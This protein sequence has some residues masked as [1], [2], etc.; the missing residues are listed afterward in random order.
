MRW[1]YKSALPLRSRPASLSGRP[2]GRWSDGGGFSN[3]LLCT[4]TFKAKE[5]QQS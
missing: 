3:Y 4:R 1:N 5:R 2:Q